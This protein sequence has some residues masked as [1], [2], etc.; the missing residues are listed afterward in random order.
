M[1]RNNKS[2]QKFIDYQQYGLPKFGEIDIR[3]PRL[4]EA[5]YL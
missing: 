1:K 4:T 2:V 3:Q 5:K